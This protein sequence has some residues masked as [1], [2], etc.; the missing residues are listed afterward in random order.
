[1]FVSV[2]LFISATSFCDYMST[3]INTMISTVSCDIRVSDDL[4]DDSKALYDKLR[5]TKGVTKSSYYFNLSTE[6]SI[7]AVVPDSS[8]SEEYRNGVD[9][10]GGQ[11]NEPV[12]EKGNVVKSKTQLVDNLTVVFMENQAFDECVKQNG[13]N[14]KFDALAYDAMSNQTRDG[15]M[16]KYPLFNKI[17]NEVEVCFPKKLPKHYEDVYVRRVGKNGELECRM[18]KYLNEEA[19][20]NSERFVPYKEFY[21]TRKITIGKTLDKAP[22][23][24][25]NEVGS[26]L[27]L[28]L[29]ERAMAKICPAGIEKLMVMLYNSDNPTE[30]SEKMC[31]VLE[32]NDR[33]TGNLYNYAREIQDV[34]AMMLVIK[35]F[36]YGFIILISLISIA[37]VFNTISTNILLRRRE[38]AVL[39]SVGMTR[40]GFYKMM[41][42]EC[43]L[44][45]CKGLFFGLIASV[46]VTYLIYLSL[47]NQ[48]ILDF[49][50]PWYSVVI[51]VF[52]VFFVV[53]CTMLY[54]MRK[55]QKDN[56]AETL[57]SDV[58]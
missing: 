8:I 55:I 17:P 49:Y 4:T 19:E 23:G 27:V 46:G 38:F 18:E 26:G 56:V 28:F 41:N 48:M 50:I 44:Y 33:S 13:A 11:L 30:R 21:N 7:S 42:L 16:Y 14:G 58:F 24:M 54:A 53:F 25:E 29:P 40:H 36:S 35:I 22:F 12:D 2:V 1:M 37:N 32:N 43:I 6:S 5:V 57:K 10:E 47:R 45:G 39:R 20:P 31:Q 15:K 9:G 52:S 51:A 3:A 34:R